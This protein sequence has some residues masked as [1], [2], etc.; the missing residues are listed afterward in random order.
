MTGSAA[1]R[2]ASTHVLPV[3]AGRFAAD[4]RW[5]LA[6]KRPTSS[7]VM[8]PG[9]SGQG[10]CGSAGRVW[11]LLALPLE[12]L[13]AAL[14]AKGAGGRRQKGRTPMLVLTLAGWLLFR[15]AAQQLGDPP[16]RLTLEAM[17]GTGP[18]RRRGTKTD[19]GAADWCGHG[20][21]GR[22]SSGRRP[23]PGSGGDG[24]APALGRSGA[25]PGECAAGCGCADGCARQ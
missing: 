21:C 25:V 3:K 5:G 12:S 19:D 16:S 11:T 17:P 9:G 2:H 23:G 7:L 18:R 13:P 6:A 10:L 14:T 22:S 1:I 15:L 4:W 8:G 24:G 20:P